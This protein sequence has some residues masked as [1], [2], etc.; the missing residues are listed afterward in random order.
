MITP[1]EFIKTMAQ[2]LQ[3]ALSERKHLVAKT[4]FGETH[5]G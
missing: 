3:Q 1:T 5:K 4:L 2:K